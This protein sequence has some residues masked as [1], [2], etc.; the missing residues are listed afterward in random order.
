MRSESFFCTTWSLRMGLSWIELLQAFLLHTKL[1]PG[2]FL[3]RTKKS[4]GRRDCCKTKYGNNPPA[5]PSV[6]DG[7]WS[8]KVL[9]SLSKLWSRQEEGNNNGDPHA[10]MTVVDSLD[11]TRRR[12]SAH[13]HQ[14]G[15]GQ[16]RNE[17]MS[18]A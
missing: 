13:I 18:W 2:H 16:Y 6:A 4:L 1:L 5:F 9:L 7:H 15:V 12:F 11:S 8:C 14:L 17:P 10:V 3:R